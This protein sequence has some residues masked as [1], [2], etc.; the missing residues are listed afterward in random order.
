MLLFYSPTSPHA[1]KVR[2]YPEGYSGS[3]VVDR[4]GELA[5]DTNELSASAR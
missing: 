3:P 2:I 1:R 4:R 5:F